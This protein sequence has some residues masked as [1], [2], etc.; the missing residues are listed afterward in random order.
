MELRLFSADDVVR[1]LP[2]AEAI[3]GM[4]SA[5]AQLSAGEAVLPLRAHI[6]VSAA[7]TTLVMP[8]YL[9]QSD[10]LGLKV[11][12]VFNSNPPRGLKL[13]N[14]VVIA[15]DGATGQPLAL[16]EGGSVTAIRTG[17]ASGAGTD[18]LA[19]PDAEVAAIFGAG[20]QARTQLEAVCTVRQI[21]EVRVYSP[22]GAESFA[23]EMVGRGPIP[24]TIL[25][26]D[27]PE[28]A[29]R[30]ADIICTATT[31]HTP[32]FDGAWLKPGA[33]VNAIGSF[34][35]EMQE[36]DA[37]TLRRSLV[38][39]DSR[40]AAL[41]ETGDLL[42]PIGRGEFAVED[43]HA[44]VGEIINGARPGRTS[45]EQITLFK[46]VGLAVQDVVAAQIIWRN[47]VE[48]GLGSTAVL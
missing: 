34:T 22:E 45:P 3:E 40:E 10:A 14:A 11:V 39:V 17:A 29:V 21:R 47:G 9:P 19:R 24:A 23:A 25:I 33:H 4:K 42:I 31:A 15:L 35:P 28:A 5:Y 2:M 12:S 44:E 38:V 46:S 20:V 32:V 27:S 43:I 18:V 16:I 41:A 48:I 37:A 26:A 7:D 30:D 13:I 36:I 8:A 1:S 6:P